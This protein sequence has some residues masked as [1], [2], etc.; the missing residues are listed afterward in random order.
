[1][2]LGKHERNLDDKGRLA[3]PAK[4]REQLPTG[5]VITIAPDSC[6]RVYPPGEWEMVTGQSRVSAGTSPTERNLIR[7]MFAEAAVLEL[8]G[9]GRTLLPSNLREQAGI[10][11]SAIVVGV[12]NVVE[13]WSQE[14]WQ[15]L[16][17]NTSDFTR[18]ADEVASQRVDTH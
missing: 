15:T 9:Q 7:R 12:N 3:V 17:E 4:F 2:F 1:M 6:L 16:E 10:A 14:R 18:L 8:D 13:I 11:A 5:S